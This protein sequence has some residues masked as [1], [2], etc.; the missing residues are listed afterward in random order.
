MVVDCRRYLVLLSGPG[1]S[2]P[3]SVPATGCCGIPG[4]QAGDSSILVLLSQS[5]WLL[6]LCAAMPNRLAASTGGSV[7]GATSLH[8][9]SYVR[10]VFES[11]S[12]LYQL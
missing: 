4:T 1:V 5:A 9:E 8:V 12:L 10:H 3:Q 2:L 6:P 7:T 11:E